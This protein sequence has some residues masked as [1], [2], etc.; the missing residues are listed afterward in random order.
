MKHH[1]V[2]ARFARY[3]IP[4]VTGMLVSSL[5]VVVDGIFVGRGVGPHGLAAINLIWPYIAVF[6]AAALMVGVGGAALCAHAL[7]AGQP[8]EAQ[9]Y[10]AQ[11]LWLILGISVVFSVVGFFLT[12]T[13]C[14]LL[15]ADEAIL[16]YCVDYLRWYMV[17]GVPYGLSMVFGTFCRNDNDPGLAFVAMIAGSVLNVFLDYLAIYLLHGGMMGAAVASGIGQLCSA[18]MLSYHFWGKR[19]VLRLSL[20]RPCRAVMTLVLRTGTPELLQ[21]L[22]CPVSMVAYNYALMAMVGA[23]GVAAYGI[24]AYILTIL[25]SLFAGVSQGIQPI[26]SYSC[27]A[28]DRVGLRRFFR[29]GLG[30]NLGLSA[31]LCLLLRLLDDQVIGIFTTDAT[32]AARAVDAFG[33]YLPS[34]LFGAVNVVCITYFLSVRQTGFANLLSFARGVV[35]MLLFIL[36]LPPLLGEAGIW[37]TITA[38]EGVTLLLALVCFWRVKKMSV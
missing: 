30:L 33:L 29:L 32:L 8:T 10:F 35:L 2:G 19:G 26:L 38:A 12:P 1:S 22:C 31:V 37:L 9:G 20:P 14:R 28:G 24:V 17:F 3:V 16:P 27:G 18:L 21:N 11:S 15:G 6:I 7:G 13:L 36:L 25:T 5:Y 23:D 34:C 4:S